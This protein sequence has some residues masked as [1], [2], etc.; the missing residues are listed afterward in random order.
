MAS[1]APSTGPALSR[2]ATIGRSSGRALDGL[3]VIEFTTG[4]SAP[5]IGRHLAFN[6]AEVIRV[7]SRAHPDLSRLYIPPWDP[8]LGQQP[9]LS[10]RL[11]EWHA[12]KLHTALNLQKPGGVGLVRR[13][14]GVSDVVICNLAA[15]VMGRWGIPYESLAATNPA[16][17]VLSMPGFGMTG[18]YRDYVSFGATIEAVSGLATSTGYPDG[19][20]IGS[21]LFHFPDWLNGMQGLTAIL[22]AIDGRRRTGRGQHIDMS[23]ME[24][25][26]SALGPL[27]MQAELDPGAP[28][29]VGNYSPA[30]APHNAYPCAGNPGPPGCGSD[31]LCVIAVFSDDEWT[32]L[33]R[34]MEMSGL[35]SDPRFATHAARLRHIGEL[36]AAIARWTRTLDAGE[37]MAR[38]Q[39]AGVRAAK[40]YRIDELLTDPNLAHQRFFQEIPHMK[41]GKALATGLAIDLSETPGSVARS[42]PPWGADNDHVFREVVGLSGAE[43]ATL[44]GAGA[45]E[46]GP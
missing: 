37:V 13:L 27:V 45:I 33:C 25:M 10:P 6:G 1:R 18:P 32:S 35:A 5:W 31:T 23:Q 14:I 46:S 3:R 9:Q 26:V 29:R 40:V 11:V 44:A 38:L 8:G 19:D 41:K 7:E 20:P 28:D 24:V 43:F 16:L 36:D 22:A 30:A 4:G 2:P 21:G 17:I 15:G 34:A 39:A 12:G 42:G